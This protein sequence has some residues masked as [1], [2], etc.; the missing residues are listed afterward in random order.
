M[1]FRTKPQLALEM[2]ADAVSEQVPFR[3]V[4]GDSIYGNSPTFV[5]GSANSASG[6]YWIFR[7]R[8]MSGQKS[9]R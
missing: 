8:L 5:Q 4:G 9:L 1:I 3:W 6:M 2:L 7:P